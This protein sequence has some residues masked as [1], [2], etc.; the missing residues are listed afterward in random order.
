MKPGLL[1]CNRRFEKFARNIKFPIFSVTQRLGLKEITP[2]PTASLS[3]TTLRETAC[4]NDP[5]C[6]LCYIDLFSFSCVSLNDIKIISFVPFSI[7]SNDLIAFL[8]DQ[9]QK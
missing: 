1:V 2:A 5:L 6:T 9:S 7:R 4:A 3:N 8:S